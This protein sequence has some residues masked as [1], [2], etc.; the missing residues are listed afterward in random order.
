MAVSYAT[1]TYKKAQQFNQKLSELQETIDPKVIR[2]YL[3]NANR[4]QS[5]DVELPELEGLSEDDITAL[6]ELRTIRTSAIQ[7]EM[8]YALAQA[9]KN[10][11]TLP[12]NIVSGETIVPGFSQKVLDKVP[13]LGVYRLFML[14]TEKELDSYLEQYEAEEP[15]AKPTQDDGQR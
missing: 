7:G 2:T 3:A 8:K 10:G 4:V 12:E 9:K 6:E 14:F 5:E 1:S 13:S 15:K 11:I